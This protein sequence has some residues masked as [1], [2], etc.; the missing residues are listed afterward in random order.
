VIQLTRKGVSF[1]G[2]QEDLRSLRE[3]YEINNYVILPQ[4]FESA[5]FEEMFQRVDAA[6]F[7]PKEHGK[8]SLEFCMNDAI[9]NAMLEFFPNN[10]IFLRIIEQITGQPRIGKFSGRVYR[11]TS[12]D[13]HFDRWHSD[14]ADNRVVTMSVNL[15]RKE[16]SGGAL[17]IRYDNSNEILQEVRNTGFGDALLFRISD[18]LTHRVQAIEGDIPKTA[19]AGWF[20]EGEDFLPNLRRVAQGAW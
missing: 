17:Q 3:K 2:T 7:L 6:P 10:P 20:L 4:L 9:T 14:C 18:N 12:S 13:G 5:L 11:M 19:F 8:L 1:T 15:S 16:F